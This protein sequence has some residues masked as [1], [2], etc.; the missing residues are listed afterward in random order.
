MRSNNLFNYVVYGCLALLFMAAAYYALQQRKEQAAKEEEMRRD[1]EQLEQSLSN[2][3]NVGDS[4]ATSGQSAYV[5]EGTAGAKPAPTTKTGANKD[6]IEDDAA[7]AKPV[8]NV[9]SGAKTDATAKP[10]ATKPAPAPAPKTASTQP[11][12]DPKKLVAKSGATASTSKQSVAPSNNGRFL[13]VVGAFSQIENARTEMEKFVKMGYQDAEVI[14]YKEN[15]WR[16]VAKRCSK[17]TDADKY[18]GDLERHGYDAMI[19]DSAKK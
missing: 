17:R 16:V 10:A 9:P 15:L 4:T 12:T 6:G 5:G 3:N 7:P 18:E 1:R 8:T 14:K 11:V 19:V 2:M 13:V